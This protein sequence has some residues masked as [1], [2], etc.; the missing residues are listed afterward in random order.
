MVSVF[1]IRYNDNGYEY[2]IIKR[3]TPSYNWQC[4]TGGVEKGETPLDAA[5]RELLEETGYKSKKMHSYGYG[6]GYF[7][8][9][10][11]FGERDEKLFKEFLATIENIVYIAI[12]DET[13]DPVTDPREHTDWKWCDYQTAYD[14]ILW[15][16]EKK[17]LRLIVEYLS[18]NL[19]K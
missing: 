4:V 19:T 2:L 13:Q 12:I 10:E 6:E 14:Y 15:S 5:H 9:D 7:V 17:Q 8:D 18:S 1:P 3:A 11:P 16:I